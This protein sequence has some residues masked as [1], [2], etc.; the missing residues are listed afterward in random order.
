MT[1]A[2]VALLNSK[3]SLRE[4][5][6]KIFKNAELDPNWG[7]RSTGPAVITSAHE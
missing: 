7:E 4:L 1:T 6:W 2:H 5:G 3:W